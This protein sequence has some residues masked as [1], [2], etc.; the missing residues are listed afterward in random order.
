MNN[1][2]INTKGGNVNSIE[3]IGITDHCYERFLERTGAKDKTE[4]KILDIIEKGREVVSKNNVM[5]LIRNGFKDARYY[6]YNDLVAVVSCDT[7]SVLTVMKY[8]KHKWAAK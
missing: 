3:G 4:R 5:K 6:H 2:G 8:T 7:S 1:G